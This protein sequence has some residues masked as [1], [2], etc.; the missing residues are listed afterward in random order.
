MIYELKKDEFFKCKN[1][2]SENNPDSVAVISGNNPGRIF[3]DNKESP[4]TGLVWY[5]S[6]DIGFNFIGNCFNTN[7]NKEIGPFVEEYIK[8]EAKK[9]GM[10]WFEVSGGHLEWD[11]TVKDIFK[12]RNVETQE[13]QVYIL[14]ESD[15][16]PPQENYLPVDY[17]LH[18]ISEYSL[19][20]AGNSSFLY[21]KILSFWDSIHDFLDKGLGY[22]II[23]N[24]KI[25]SYCFSGFVTNKFSVTDVETL[26]EYRG[27]KLAQIVTVAYVRECF[28]RGLTPY[29]DCMRENIPSNALAKKIGF[30]K[31]STYHVQYFQF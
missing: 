20:M 23:Y 30:E 15:N 21:E 9:I 2:I 29:W 24:N 17:E 25:V 28:S 26:E 27:G 1:L 3:V 5:K 6:L 12:H 4:T 22:C 8:S 19:I 7:F 13:Q 10:N 16:V 14:H 31:V 11:R 18:K